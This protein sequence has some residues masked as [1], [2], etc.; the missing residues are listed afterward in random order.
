MAAMGERSPSQTLFGLLLITVIVLI[1]PALGK[2]C[3]QVGCCMEG[4][5]DACNN[6][7]PVQGP[8]T[9]CY[10]DSFCNRTQSDCCPDF[11]EVCL[12]L[13][14]PKPIVE[15][16]TC[17]HGKSEYP[18]GDQIKINCNLCTCKQQLPGFFSFECETN[19]CLI[20]E[21]LADKIN[22]GDHGWTAGNYSKFWGKRLDEGVKHRLGT[23]KPRP[24]VEAMNEI[25]MDDPGVGELP[26][27]FDAREH[28]PELL[29]PVMDQGDCASSWAFSTAAVASDRLSIQ[30][31]GTM[32]VDLSPQHLL[33]CNVKRQQGCHGGHLDRAW[34]YLRKKGIV[35][36]DCYPYKSGLTD[37]MKMERGQCYI[38]G[39]RSEDKMHCPMKGMKSSRY[40][41]TPPYRIS[42]SSEEIQMEIMK[43]GPVQAA[44]NVREDFFMYQGGV[45]K[46][47][48]LTKYEP[49]PYKRNGW[50]S[51]RIIGWGIDKKD[52]D[53]HKRYWLAAN[54]WGKDW[55]EDGFFRVERGSN[56]CEIESF[57]VGAWGKVETM[58]MI[59]KTNGKNG[60][61]NKNDQ[62]A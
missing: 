51:V 6:P 42:P 15:K 26:E 17:C 19:P 56:E 11:W 45:Y 21:D 47:T 28:W 55:G 14:P 41:S 57:V 40:Q 8:E 58:E 30:S 54:S 33:S 22:T 59:E 12:G 23:M 44:F 36:N 5:D 43:N 25:Q 31:N 52:P 13:N 37:E 62:Y 29:E 35:T 1:V 7:Y 4:R 50:H 9:L 46:Y 53:N 27:S 2:Y 3:A 32:K 39:A 48:D 34:W 16:G 18:S 20:R 61:S 24:A 38:P 10:C 49:E 60:H